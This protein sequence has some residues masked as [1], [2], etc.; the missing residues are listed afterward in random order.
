MERIYLDNSA[1]T[2]LDPAVLEAMMPYLTDD[3]GNASSIHTFGQTAKMAV[4]RARHQVAALLN[5]TRPNEIIFTSGGTESNNLAIR[6]LVEANSRH[7]NHIILSAIEHPAVESVCEDLEKRGFELTVLPVYEN[8]IVKIEDVRAAIRDDTI[9]ITVMAANNEIGTLQPINEI[10]SLVRDLRR[11]G[12]KIWFHTD[13]VQ[14]VGKIRVDVEEIGCDLLSF[15][16][17]KIN[18]P[19]GV[20]GLYVR[21]G[22]R[23]HTQNIGGRQERGTRAGT[24][25]VPGIVGLGSAAELAGSTLDDLD[26]RIR[27]L[28]DRIENDIIERVQDAIKNGE[29]KTRLQNIENISLR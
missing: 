4:D 21:R 11:S 23:L 13:A 5:A 25:N 12:K 7:G 3:F 19:K 1:T 10:G 6:G 26:T 8:G 15:S 29:R 22:V 20:G 24:E 9:L 18:G 28:S 27:S 16:G 17:H 14:A 2:P